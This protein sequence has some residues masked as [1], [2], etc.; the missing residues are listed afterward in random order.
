MFLGVGQAVGGAATGEADF[1]HFRDLAGGSRHVPGLGGDDQA[2]LAEVG[3][4]ER[5]EVGVGV[6]HLA[7][8]D[9]IEHFWER[10]LDV[11]AGQPGLARGLLAVGGHGVAANAKDAH[12]W[13]L[14]DGHGDA[15]FLSSG[16]GAGVEV[17]GKDVGHAGLPTG[18]TLDADLGGVA[19]RPCVHVGEVA[20][21]ALSRAERHA[22]AAWVVSLGH[23][24]VLLVYVAT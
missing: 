14:N 22:T 13:H 11:L 17:A 19:L 4:F 5:G 12:L 6:V 9:A 8:G 3:F 7:G 16:G 18:E 23:G 21:R 1:H 15:D 24:V 10:L 2:N 20:R